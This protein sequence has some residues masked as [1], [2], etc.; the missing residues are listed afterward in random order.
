MSTIST[1]FDVLDDVYLVHTSSF[2]IAKIR[3]IKICE[4][5]EGTHIEYRL[6]IG[7][8]SLIT[9]NEIDLHHTPE[10]ML[11][12]IKKLKPIKDK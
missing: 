5:F 2:R 11:D 1:K 4:T 6:D 3:E 12:A 10:E 8:K 9:K 7:N